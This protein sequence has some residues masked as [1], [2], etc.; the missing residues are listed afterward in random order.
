[1]TI[2]VT[3]TKPSHIKAAQAVYQAS[4]PSDPEQQA[5][6]A[7]ETEC[8]K[9]AMDRVLDS[10]AETTGVDRIAVAAFVRRFPGSVMDAIVASDDPVV[11]QILATIDSVTHVRLGAQTTLDAMAYFVGAGYITQAQSDAILAY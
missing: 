10:W 5:P 1:M 8:V 9:A 6:Y 2:T 11:I 4:I 7:D 3:L